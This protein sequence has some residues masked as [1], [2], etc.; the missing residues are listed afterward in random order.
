M[1]ELAALL[2][3]IASLLAQAEREDDPAR[4]ERTLTDGYARALSLEAERM[5]L[6]RRVRQLAVRLA[7]DEGSGAGELSSLVC[8]LEGQNVAIEQLRRDLERLRRRHSV[9]VRD[10]AGA[11][12]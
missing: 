9:A 12:P 11:R 10:A 1:S 6:E 8:R 5:R 4:L 7:R 3:E 2:T